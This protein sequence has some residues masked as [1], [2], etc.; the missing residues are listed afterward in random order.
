MANTRSTGLGDTGNARERN[1]VFIDNKTRQ[2][3]GQNYLYL[4]YGRNDKYRN[5]EDLI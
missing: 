4:D 2:Y 5:Y 1:L 3:L